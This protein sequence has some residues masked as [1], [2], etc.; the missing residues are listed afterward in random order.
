[1]FAFG[2]AHGRKVGGREGKWGRKEGGGDGVVEGR[3]RRKIN[4]CEGP[5]EAPKRL[6]RRQKEESLK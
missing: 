6:A 5:A 2:N 3:A 1:M 4:R